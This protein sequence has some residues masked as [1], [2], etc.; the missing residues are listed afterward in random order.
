MRGIRVGT[1]KCENEAKRAALTHRSFDIQRASHQIDQAPG[2]GQPESRSAKTP[3]NALI[4]LCEWI[5]QLW[6]D[7]RAD[8]Y[9]GIL[10]IET[11]SHRIGIL[12]QRSH[13]HVDL[14]L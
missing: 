13:R 2:N 12:A 8:A 6:K 11:D 14:A 1:P 9:A 10:H 5:E 4:G 3:G 7:V